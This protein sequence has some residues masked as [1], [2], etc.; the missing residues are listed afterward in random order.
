M[1]DA[2]EAGIGVGERVNGLEEM[3]LDVEACETV[4]SVESVESCLDFRRKGTEGR[5]YLG[6]TLG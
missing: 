6:N 5:R 4:E 3:V 1:E 2:E